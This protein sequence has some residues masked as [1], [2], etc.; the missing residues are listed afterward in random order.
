M[1]HSIII[2]RSILFHTYVHTKNFIWWVINNQS[3][4]RYQKYLL[5]KKFLRNN[6][7]NFL[8]NRSDVKNWTNFPCVYKACLRARNL[9][10]PSIFNAFDWMNLIMRSGSMPNLVR[11]INFHWRDWKIFFPRYTKATFNIFHYLKKNLIMLIKK[12]KN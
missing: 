8:K 12:E 2:K 11:T 7:K 1:R 6:K 5:R 10:Y 4:A 9:L 3:Y